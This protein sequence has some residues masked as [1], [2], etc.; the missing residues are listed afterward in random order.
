LFE[1]TKLCKV[2]SH[3][4]LQAFVDKVFDFKDTWKVVLKFE[5]TDSW[6][7]DFLTFQLFFQF[8][9]YIR[10]TGVEGNHRQEVANRV[11]FGFDPTASFPLKPHLKAAGR[12]EYDLVD[13]STVNKPVKLSIMS[14]AGKQ[15]F[16]F[17]LLFVPPLTIRS[18]TI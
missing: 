5:S 11:L 8:I 4:S 2:E 6:Q 12:K 3:E 9:T 14:K 18:L 17:N 1:N 15:N 13:D 10:Q 7:Y 16:V